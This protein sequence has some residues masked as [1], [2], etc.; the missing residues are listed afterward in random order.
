MNE[1]DIATVLAVVEALIQRFCFLNASR[2]LLTQS[3]P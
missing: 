2:P 1:A 3:D